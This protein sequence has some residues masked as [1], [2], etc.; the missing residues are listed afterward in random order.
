MLR[1]QREDKDAV[2]FDPETLDGLQ[3]IAGVDLSFPLGDHVNAVACLVVMSMPHLEVNEPKKK[4]EIATH[5]SMKQIVY[6]QFLHTKLH[7][8]YISG[9]LAFREVNPLLELLHQLKTS[10]PELYPQIILVDG[11]I[12]FKCVQ[13]SPKLNTVLQEMA[14]CTHADLG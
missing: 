10:K 13:R 14:F 2:D 6:K 5:C 11:K 9:Y 8:P 4:S 12:V 3:Y 7:L 1:E